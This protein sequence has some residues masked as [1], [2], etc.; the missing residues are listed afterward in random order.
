M[1]EVKTGIMQHPND[2]ALYI[3]RKSPHGEG[4]VVLHVTDTFKEGHVCFD[5]TNR[6]HM[7][8]GEMLEQKEEMFTFR[9]KY[10]DIWE[11]EIV[12]IEKFD[13]EIYQYVY[14][15]ESI[16]EICNTTEDLWK[17]Y[18]KTFPM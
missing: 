11:F 1:K 5:D 14:N 8:R 7:I 10:G 2:K 15:G 13:E 18:R 6:G 9:D 3:I 12:T 16:L 17:Y 4:Q